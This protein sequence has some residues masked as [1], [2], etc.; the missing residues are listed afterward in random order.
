MKRA[1]IV[2][3]V[4]A[5]GCAHFSSEQKDTLPDATVRT[6]R[7]RITTFFDAHNDVSKLRASTTDKTQGLSMA[8]L[9][10]SASGTNA[11]DFAERIIG[12]AVRAAIKP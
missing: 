2:L 9:D 4:A 5:T 7:I 11:V 1:L 10:Q 6:T 3:C 8:G 12:A